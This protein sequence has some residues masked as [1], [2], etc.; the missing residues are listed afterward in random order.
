MEIRKEE[1]M[2]TI[3]TTAKV[4]DIKKGTLVKRTPTAKKLYIRGEYN[5][6]DKKYEL[7]SYD[8]IS[9]YV[10]VKKGTKLFIDWDT[11]NED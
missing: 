4:E 5:K 10:N 2:E 9:A 3:Y 11:S 8:D 6:F 7:Q 1:I